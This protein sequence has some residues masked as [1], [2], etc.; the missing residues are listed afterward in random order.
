MPRTY[1]KRSYPLEGRLL[2]FATK[3]LKESGDAY[4]LETLKAGGKINYI[5]FS[6]AMNTLTIGIISAD[7][8]STCAAEL[9]LPKEF[10][11]SGTN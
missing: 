9:N 5:A 1:K 2:N 3:L 11:K 8:S 4:P 6:L 10:F 7:E